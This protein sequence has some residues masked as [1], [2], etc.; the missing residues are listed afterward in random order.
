[1]WHVV[2]H[3]TAHVGLTERD[4]GN[5][6]SCVYTC[7]GLVS[8]LGETPV[9]TVTWVTIY[10]HLL[11]HQISSTAFP[12]SHVG[13]NVTVE[14]LKINSGNLGPCMY[15]RYYGMDA[16]MNYFSLSVSIFSPLNKAVTLILS[17]GPLLQKSRSHRPDGNTCI[18]ILF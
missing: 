4:G 13:G 8:P 11:W 6:R 14:G 1:M 2:R 12:P 10:Q 17:V 5:D 18:Y 7:E 16:L 15:A 3:S 9:V